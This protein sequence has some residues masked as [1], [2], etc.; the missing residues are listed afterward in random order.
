VITVNAAKEPVDIALPHTVGLWGKTEPVE[1]V[2]AKGRN[3]LRVA[4]KSDGY[5]KGFTIRDMTLSPAR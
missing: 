3:V 2:L 5:G 4:H 1:V